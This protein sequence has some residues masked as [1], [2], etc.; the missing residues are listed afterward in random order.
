MTRSSG[1]E[2]PGAGI[3][4]YVEDDAINI[5][6]MER[7]FGT[8]PHLELRVAMTGAQALAVALDTSLS[9]ILLDRHLPDMLG[10]E[11]LRRL[12]GQ[13][14]EAGIPVIVL[15]GDTDRQTIVDF[16]RLGAAAYITKPF[17]LVELLALIDKHSQT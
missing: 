8:R 6:L 4:L 13:D 16:E 17:D 10:N 5:R 1:S 14:P 2:P 9:L 3:V 7:I 11:F 12:I 15:S